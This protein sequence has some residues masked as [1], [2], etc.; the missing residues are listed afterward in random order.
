[1]YDGF[2]WAYSRRT[3]RKKRVPAHH[4]GHPTLGKAWRLTPLQR[5]RDA[6]KKAARK[7]RTTD[8][9]AEEQPK[10]TTARKA[11]PSKTPATGDNT[12]KEQ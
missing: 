6:E 7:A 9:A 12:M 11:S 3:G 8:T 10:K 5:V 1:M 4:I 2:V